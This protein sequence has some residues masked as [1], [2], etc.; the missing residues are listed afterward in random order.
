VLGFRPL[1]ACIKE[2]AMGHIVAKLWRE[3]PWARRSTSNVIDTSNWSSKSAR[4]K[5]QP[6]SLASL[7]VT[8]EKGEQ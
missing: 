8:R 1:V 4:L 6:Q 3:W 7:I 2:T 5:G